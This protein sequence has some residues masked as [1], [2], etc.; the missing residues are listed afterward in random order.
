MSPPTRHQVPSSIQ[1]QWGILPACASKPNALC[2]S[3]TTAGQTHSDFGW[4]AKKKKKKKIK[5]NPNLLSINPPTSAERHKKTNQREDRESRQ[6]SRKRSFRRSCV[7]RAFSIV[8]ADPPFLALAG[9]STEIAAGA[10]IL[11]IIST[12]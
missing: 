12:M 8:S 2:I 5:K 6:S 7:N 9:V 1:E 4:E 11:A 3:G 10:N